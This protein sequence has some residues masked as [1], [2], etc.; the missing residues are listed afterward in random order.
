MTVSIFL[1]LLGALLLQ[2]NDDV[3]AVEEDLSAAA[4]VK[5]LE[6]LERELVKQRERWREERLQWASE[7][8]GWFSVTGR[9]C[10]LSAATFSP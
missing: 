7:R 1:L 3:A 6:R 4:T 10:C 5:R 2:G 9:R 8:H